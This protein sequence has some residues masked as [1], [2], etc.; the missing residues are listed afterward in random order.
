M[1]EFKTLPPV[2][3]SV[4]Y[5]CK[6]CDGEKYHRVLAHKT[7]TSASIECESCGSKKTLKLA[8]AKKKASSGTT[9]RKRVTAQSKIPKMWEEFNEKVGVES[10][11]P[12]KISSSFQEN[13]AIQ[14]VKFGM[15][16]VTKA[17]SHKIEVV[18][19]DSIK[20]LIHN[21]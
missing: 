13:Q 11:V 16:Y 20:E 15:G 12:Y 21:R 8:S 9:T 4:S 5:Q 3:K 1:T 7:A 6:K 14:H 2:A 17:F 10:A 18:F 19:Q